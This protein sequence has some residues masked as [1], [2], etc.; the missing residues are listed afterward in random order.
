[1]DLFLP[2]RQA[3]ESTTRQFGGTGL[4]LSIVWELVRKMGGEVGAHRES[5]GSTFWCTL[6]LEQGEAY[7]ESRIV[8]DHALLLVD[9]SVL[10]GI[11]QYKTMFPAPVR[12]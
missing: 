2:F 8:Y 12:W 1:M 9:D 6:E 10:E 11:L 5:V 3:D 7:A 4:G